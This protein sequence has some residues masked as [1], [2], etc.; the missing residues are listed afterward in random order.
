MHRAK[1]LEE[2]LFF[3]ISQGLQYYRSNCND[4]FLSNHHKLSFFVTIQN[5]TTT[6]AKIRI[7]AQKEYCC[8][9]NRNCSDELKTK[10]SSVIGCNP[11]KSIVQNIALLVIRQ[12]AES[13]YNAYLRYILLHGIM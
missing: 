3:C 8:Q 7:H 4:Y 1:F 6:N 5:P 2:T 11:I 9:T 13:N 12:Y 10:L